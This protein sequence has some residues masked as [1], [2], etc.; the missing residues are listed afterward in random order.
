MKSGTWILGDTERRL[1]FGLPITNLLP[2]W[3]ITYFPSQDGP[4]H[5]YNA[6]II[7]DWYW[8]DFNIF[9]EYLTLNERLDPTW[10]D[11]IIRATLM[12]VF[13]PNISE[14]LFVSVYILGLPLS[15]RYALGVIQPAAR[16]LSVLAFP[17]LYNALLH[18]GF[19]SFSM[20]LAVYC[21]F[22]GYWLQQ[23]RLLTS[24]LAPG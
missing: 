12:K 6:R 24:G 8:S 4:A 16:F 1:F 13:S 19:Y 2:L 9:R 21:F 14:K 17:L 22:I 11:H 7:G 5:L 10:F 15:I 20:S 3:L 18:Y 23:R